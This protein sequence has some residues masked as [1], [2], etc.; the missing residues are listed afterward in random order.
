[1]TERVL[2]QV[3]ATGKEFLRRVHGV[4]PRDKVRSYEIHK[5]LNLEPFHPIERS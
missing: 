4:T 5:T 1:M 2:S 3:Q